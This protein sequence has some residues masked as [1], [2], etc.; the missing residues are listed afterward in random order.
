[1]TSAGARLL[2]CVVASL[3]GGALQAALVYALLIGLFLSTPLSRYGEVH[4]SS[5]D[6]MQ[7]FGL[8]RVEGVK[9]PGNPL[10]SDAVTQM[11]PWLMFNRA[12]LAEGRFPLWNPH[13]GAGCP[14]F[15]N[16]Q[17]AV[18][19][20]FSVPFYVLGFK[21][22]LLASA[23]LKLLSLALFTYL[24]LRRLG[25]AHAAALLGGA[26]FA[27]AGHNVLLLYF[28][29]VGA[30]V[31]LPA[32]CLAVEIAAQRTRRAIESGGRARLFGPLAGLTAAF[33]VGLLAGNPEPFY[34]SALFVAAFTLARLAGLWHDLRALEGAR[35][36][37]AAFAS[38]TAFAAALAA[39]L[40][41]FQVL[42]FF[43]FLERSR[44]FE[45]RSDTQTPLD[46][47][48]WPLALFPDALGNPS[49][50]YQIA[51]EVPPPNYELVNV[52]YA[53]GT[54]LF[55]ALLSGAF[56]LRDRKARFFVVAGA[57]W[58]FYA[59]D[60]LGA[61][62]LF[63]LLP[64]V[65]MAP[66]NRSQ[67]VWNFVVA[68]A[69][70]VFLD[71][72]AKRVGRREWLGALGIVA[73]ASVMLGAS[74]IGIDRLIER[75]A[76]VPTPHRDLFRAF[77]PPHL[78]DMSIVFGVGALA[79]ALTWLARASW[80]R[81]ALAGAALAASF[82]S[83]GWLW[84]DYNPVCEDRY[85]FPRTAA[86]TEL[87]R[88]VGNER[89]AI[90][91]E[92]TIPPDANLPYGLSLITNYDGMWVR[93]YD[94]LYRDQF[95]DTHNWRPMLRAS[96]RALRTFGVRY[97]LAKWGWNAVDNGLAEFGRARGQVPLRHEIV[98]NQDLTQTFRSRRN[99]LRTVM[100]YLGAPVDGPRCTADVEVVELA[101][102]RVVARR[103]VDVEELRRSLYAGPWIQWTYSLPLDP[104]GRPFVLHFDPIADSAGK[105]YELRLSSTDANKGGAIVAWSLPLNAYG[106]GEAKRSGRKLPG[107]VLFDFSSATG[108]FEEVATLGDFTLYRMKE[109]MPRYALVNEAVEFDS[110]ER[111]LDMLR[112]PSFDP[113]RRV[114]LEKDPG[115]AS[116]AAIVR[117]RVVQFSDHD[118]VYLVA[119]DGRSL[120]HIDDEATFLANEFLWN[121]I[122]TLAPSARSDFVFV[123]DDDREAK[124]KAGLRLVTPESPFMPQPKVLE[125][126][127]TRIR[128]EVE[129][130]QTGYLVVAQTYFPGWKAR[131]DGVEAPLLRAN[132]AFSAVQI[133]PGRFEV[134]LAYEPDSLRIGLWIGAA[135]LAA[136]ALAWAVSRRQGT[137]RTRLPT[138]EESITL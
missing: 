60:L 76:S 110:R 116:A 8:T 135:S 54:A 119:P 16:Y 31:A 20:P 98:P 42:P 107:E 44:V 137:D 56:V 29:H 45:E 27:F 5:A 84:R 63:A 94:H 65:D 138:P 47:W 130:L 40:T 75:F 115:A 129:R 22:A 118:W 11:Q 81:N 9:R 53:G 89:V 108:G 36:R 99:G 101:S 134:E 26:A 136:A 32:G 3:R 85:F 102:G 41:A 4:Y 48:M 79:A 37:I 126:T 28:P 86:I 24:F 96:E 122:E 112:S 58:L 91:G 124:Q 35:A 23:A 43:E 67:G 13:N 14:H 105:D 93:D 33:V 80:Q 111:V 2:A 39:G 109:P 25:L 128:L 30:M 73:A 92:D 57:V 34:F 106:D 132:Y 61:A 55:L 78:R 6:L 123:P 88:I 133:P 18:V 50:P 15:A 95:G 38:R 62:K 87:S 120:V 66:M 121:Q 10:Q 114:V 64:T 19:S 113:R 117:R 97:V 74:L 52:A 104:R 59:Y 103:T 46:P 70:A 100:V 1:M 12:E 68:C 90:L 127:P 131:L 51:I 49:Q 83:T 71:R 69:A 7:D 125:E 77:V 72:A 17:S 21:A 82:A